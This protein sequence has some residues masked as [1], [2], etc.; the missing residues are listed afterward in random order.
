MR[1]RLEDS[2]LFKVDVERTQYT[3]GGQE[4]LS[5]YR[6]DSKKVTTA[7][8]E[9]QTD[10]DFK[11]DFSAYDVVI[12]NFGWKTA[13]WPIETQRAFEAYVA[14]GGDFVSVHA[15]DNAFATWPEY[16]LMIG[17]GGWGGRD[18]SS[19][20][21]VYLNDQGHQVIDTQKGIRQILDLR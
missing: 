8:D 21:M 5:R 4:L 2:G 16:N 13:D 12:S 6:I 7:V 9:P 15:A 20:P 10:P 14:N 1:D 18:E 11:P 19:G 17:L 3:W